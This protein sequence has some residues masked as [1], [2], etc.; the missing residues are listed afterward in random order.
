MA[1]SNRGPKNFGGLGPGKPQ[2]DTPERRVPEAPM[3]PDFG[4][5]PSHPLA[6][7]S[8]PPKSTMKGPADLNPSSYGPGKGI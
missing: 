4:G 2:P 1:A 5:Q 6:A 3:S 8:H 7:C